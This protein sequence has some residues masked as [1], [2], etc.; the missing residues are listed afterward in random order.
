MSLTPTHSN[1][2]SLEKDT[3]NQHFKIAPQAN[4]LSKFGQWSSVICVCKQV[5]AV[6]QREFLLTREANTYIPI[7][8]LYFINLFLLG[9]V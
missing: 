1:S 8:I 4:L 6:M 3:R 2:V 7:T 5:Q 9:I